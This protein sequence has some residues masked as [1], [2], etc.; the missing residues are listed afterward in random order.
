MQPNGDM[1]TEHKIEPQPFGEPPS[2]AGLDALLADLSPDRI[3]QLRVEL[4]AECSWERLEKLI[5]SFRL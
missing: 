3:E 2:M 5:E 1:T 4:E